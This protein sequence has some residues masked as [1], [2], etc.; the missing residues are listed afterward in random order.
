[1]TP[2]E[3]LNILDKTVIRNLELKIVLSK[4]V[5]KQIPQKIDNKESDD[6]VSGCHYCGEINAL[7]KPNGSRNR[8]C[9]NC[10]QAIDWSDKE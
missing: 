5:E 6:L 3:A 9:G 10:G 1:M 7:W 8:Y 2:K 4:A